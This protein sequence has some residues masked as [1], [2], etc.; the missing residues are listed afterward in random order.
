MR[1]PGASVEVHLSDEVVHLVAEGFDLALRLS[2]QGR[3][4][5]SS[6]V[7]RRMGDVSIQLFAALSCR[8]RDTRKSRVPKSPRERSHR[9][10]LA[11]CPPNRAREQAG[12]VL[13]CSRCQGKNPREYVGGRAPF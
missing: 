7:A 8:R 11:I 10:T 4:T 9:A 5:D 1:Y 13:C 3:L 2:T 6:M 12:L